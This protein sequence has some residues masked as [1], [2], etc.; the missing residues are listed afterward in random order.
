MP[1]VNRSPTIFAKKTTSM[2]GIT[3]C[4]DPVVSITRTVTL[5]V[6]RIVPPSAAAVPS[7][8]YVCR[9]TWRSGSTVCAAAATARPKICPSDAPMASEGT[10]IP[11]GAPMPYVH[12]IRDV[13]RT[14]YRTRAPIG[15]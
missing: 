3:S 1:S 11:V 12:V 6:S 2:S 9:S 10:N 8:A 13:I 5:I 4:S 7:T 15:K 14:K